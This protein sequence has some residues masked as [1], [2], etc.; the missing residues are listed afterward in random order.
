M[1]YSVVRCG[2]YEVHCLTTSCDNVVSCIRLYPFAKC[3]VSVLPFFSYILFY[4]VVVQQIIYKQM[5]GGCCLHI[6]GCLELW[7]LL[8]RVPS[9]MC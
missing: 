9:S 8:C 1:Y 3:G 7:M 4:V 5:S 6:V 2:M